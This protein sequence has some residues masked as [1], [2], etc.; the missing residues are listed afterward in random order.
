MYGV[1]LHVYSFARWLQSDNKNSKQCMR[2]YWICLLC[3]E[4]TQELLVTK[5]SKIITLFFSFL[6]G[7]RIAHNAGGSDDIIFEPNKEQQLFHYFH[8]L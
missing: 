1:Y 7:V 3:N 5:T 6:S 4:N 8:P 2:G